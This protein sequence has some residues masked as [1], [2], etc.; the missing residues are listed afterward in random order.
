MANIEV[1]VP[2]IGDYGDVPVIEILVAVGDTVKK[3]QG[4]VTLES[5]KATMEVP[6]SVAGV[7]KEIKVKL[8]DTLSE[9]SV[10]AV[11]ETEGAG[12]APAAPKAEAPG[13]AAPG[14]ASAAPASGGGSVEVTVPDIGDYSDGPVIEILVAVGDPVKKDQ[15]LVTLESD[16]ATMEVPSSAAG[17]VKEV[18]VKVGDALSEGSVVAVLEP[19]APAVEVPAKKPPV[20]PSPRAP[21]EPPAPKP[22][23]STGKPA[24]IECRIVVL[25]SGPGGYTAAFRAADLGLDTVLIERYPSL[26]GV[27]LNVGCIPS[28]AL[29]HAAAVIEEAA[30]AGDFGVEFGKPKIALD[31]LR[32]Y[33]EKVVGQLTKGLSGMARQRKV[34]VVQGVGTFVSPNEIEIV[35]NDGGKQLL[36]FEQ[37][38]IA[39]GSQAVKLPNFP[40]DDPRVMDSTDALE[41][42]EVPK[43]L[44]VVG[45][46]IIGLE[47]ATVYR[48]LGSEVT[49]VEFMDQLMPGADKDLVKP[50]ADRLKKQGVVVHLKTK[51]ATVKADKKGITVGFESADAGATPAIESGT[52][53]RVLVAVG[54]APNGRKIGA[55][56]AGVQV[57]DRGFIPVD[58]QMRTNVPHIFAIGDIVGNPML[59]H[60]ATHEGKLAAEVA[61]GEK[62]EWVARVIPSVAY[63]DPEIAWIGVTETEARAKGLKVGVAKFPWA[64]SGRAIGI[65]RTEGFTKLV[66]D[67]A[68]HRVIGGGIVGVHA[69]DLLAEIGLAIEMGAEAEDIGHTIHAHPT[70]SESVGMAAEV[71]DGTITDLYIPKKK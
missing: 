10:V 37:C 49:V 14:A 9:G 50:L 22:A 45:G 31:K 63:T 4:L 55:E 18:K 39:A 57:T 46:G 28:K 6:S 58:V 21:A 61:A 59:A 40:W 38:I 51:A 60:K 29:L 12:A 42:A 43:K 41:L 15:G 35:G 66:F 23:L 67:E 70:L 19:G 25:G 71:Y 2:D 8:G 16:K 30:H 65:G 64:A 1:K 53:D 20:A 3:D 11:L 26:G 5:D 27:C 13:A 24:D 7:V 69:G 47:M 34:R 36:R 54:R 32:E 56:K 17:V 68:T 44:L 48:A 33:K 52:W 62:K